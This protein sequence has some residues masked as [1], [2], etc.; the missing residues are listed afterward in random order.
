MYRQD[1]RE[2][3]PDL[4]L[5]SKLMP[6]VYLQKADEI[7]QLREAHTASYLP[8]S[9]VKAELKF[10][11]EFSTSAIDLGAPKGTATLF[12]FLLMAYDRFFCDVF[13]SCA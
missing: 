6:M 13:I 1:S 11:Q 12:R 5:Y 3:V 4:F 7:Q 10:I 9:H 2:H 8:L